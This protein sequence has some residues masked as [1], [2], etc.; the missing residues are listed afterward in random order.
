MQLIKGGTSYKISQHG[1]NQRYNVVT[2]LSEK[3]R[4]QAT[5]PFLRSWIY[6]MSKIQNKIRTSKIYKGV[7]IFRGDTV[8]ELRCL[9][10]ARGFR[11]THDGSAG[12]RHHL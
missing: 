5:Y 6:A 11:V 4:K 2:R 8:R 7:V 3:R 9:H 1:K 12:L 10:G